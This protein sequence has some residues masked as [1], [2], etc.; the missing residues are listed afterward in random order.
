MKLTNS[1]AVKISLIYF[2]AGSFW[3]LFSDLIVNYF[4]PSENFVFGI[5]ISKG[6]V[7]V[8]ITTIV[9][10][11]ST[12]RYLNKIKQE[13]RS[14]KQ[15]EEELRKGEKKYRLLFESNPQPMWVYEINTLK[16]V[17]VN[18]AAIAKYGYTK[19]EFLSMTVK[20]IRPEEDLEKFEKYLRERNVEEYNFTNDIVWRHKLK[21]GQI[22]YVRVLSHNVELEGKAYRIILSIDV[23]ELIK[24]KKA[25]RLSE[26]SYKRIFENIID[27]Y[28]ETTIYI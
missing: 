8:F 9:L 5:N 10:S 4:Y 28:F 7:F 16:F 19:D 14:K 3:I 23:T 13:S 2:I 27:V 11:I 12:K 21:N 20:D 15:T 17:D 24:S 22:I 6:L 18:N 1:P 25:L 26:Q